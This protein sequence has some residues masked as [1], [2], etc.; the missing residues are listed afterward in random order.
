MQIE[1]H[2]SVHFSQFSTISTPSAVK[3]I[4]LTEKWKMQGPCFG[5]VAKDSLK[6]NSSTDPVQSR[7][8]DSALHEMPPPSLNIVPVQRVNGAP[9]RSSV[10]RPFTSIAEAVPKQPSSTAH[11]E[12]S[13]MSLLRAGTTVEYENG[14][15]APS[16]RTKVSIKL[17]PNIQVIHKHRR[18]FFAT[19]NLFVGTSCGK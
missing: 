10:K 15:H 11:R 4:D 9:C 18:S 14:K 17:E 1:F 5:I 8:L 16:I 2:F 6:E 12:T 19:I 13:S 3:L 7:P